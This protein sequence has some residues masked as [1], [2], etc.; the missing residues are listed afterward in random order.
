MD[1][2]HQLLSSWQIIMTSVIMTILCPVHL[3]N[4]EQRPMAAD[5]DQA[6]IM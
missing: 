3:R 2:A 5:L 4:A 6:V 1:G